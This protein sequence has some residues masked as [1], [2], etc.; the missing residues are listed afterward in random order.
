LIF[1]NINN[2]YQLSE[3]CMQFG[4]MKWCCGQSCWHI[5]CRKI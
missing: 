2:A 3:L 5:W 4:T 1:F